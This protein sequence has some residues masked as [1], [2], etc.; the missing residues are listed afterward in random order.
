MCVCL[1]WDVRHTFF[2]LQKTFD[3]DCL[4]LYSYKNIPIL[5]EYA[6]I[7]FNNEIHFNKGFHKENTIKYLQL[8]K[9]CC[10]LIQNIRR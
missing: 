7:L 5:K 9:I 10:L 3:M 1:P 2:S 6:Y 4:F 8:E